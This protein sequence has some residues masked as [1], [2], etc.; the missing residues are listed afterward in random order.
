MPFF[1]DTNVCGKWP[2]DPQIRKKWE[3][4]SARLENKGIHYVAC[5][6]VLIELLLGLVKPE[7]QHFSKDVRRFVFLAGPRETRFLPF[8][9]AFVAK[10]VF[11][12]NSPATRLGPS[13]F[14][15]W[16]ACVL[17]AGNRGDLANGSVEMNSPQETYGIDFSIIER[18]Q[19]AGKKAFTTVMNRHRRNNKARSAENIADGILQNIGL[20]PKDDSDR[21]RMMA[22]LDAVIKYQTSL[23]KLSSKYDYSKHDSDWVD[24]QMLYYLADPTMSIVTNDR[25]LRARCASSSQAD[26][27]IMI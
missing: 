22:A 6:L 7:P 11:G 9:G 21:H 24:S 3:E 27:I 23:L 16:L 13:D 14:S 18:Q 19:E 20:I 15:Q 17:A 5:P 12:V 10:T 2:S 4:A 1:A 25:N 26:R 8:P